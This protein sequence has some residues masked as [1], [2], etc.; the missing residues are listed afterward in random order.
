[1]LENVESMSEKRHLFRRLGVALIFALSMLS[2]VACTGLRQVVPAPMVFEEQSKE[3]LKIVP[4]GTPKDQAIQL[5]E[6]AGIT[7]EFA[8]SPS[9]YYCDLWKRENGNLWHLNVALLFNDAGELYKTRP[10][11][12][13]VSWKSNQDS[14]YGSD[15]EK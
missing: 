12:S 13:D 4:L 15:V 3:L 11:Q 7:G 9:I 14:A 2:L 10:A 1:M 6:E 5:L 8:S